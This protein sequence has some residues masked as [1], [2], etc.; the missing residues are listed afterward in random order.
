M[1]KR[2]SSF[3]AC[4]G[5][6]LLILK[7]VQNKELDCGEITSVTSMSWHAVFW[8]LKILVNTGLLTVVKAR[9]LN[10][11][12]KAKRRY[13]EVARYTLSLQGQQALEY[14]NQRRD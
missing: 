5:K 4:S 7:A 1:I 6:R 10:I 8:H 13:R 3:D 14:F 12:P 11:N 2:L 9:K